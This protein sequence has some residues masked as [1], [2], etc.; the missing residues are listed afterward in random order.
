M[1]STVDKCSSDD[2]KQF[3]VFF[4][5]LPNNTP[6]HAFDDEFCRCWFLLTNEHIFPPEVPAGDLKQQIFEPEILVDGLVSIH[7]EGV[8][9]ENELAQTKKT[10]TLLGAFDVIDEA[11]VCPHYV[12]FTGRDSTLRGPVCETNPCM[13]RFLR[14][15]HHINI[16]GVLRLGV[17]KATLFAVALGFQH[18]KPGQAHTPHPHPHGN[19]KVIMQWKQNFALQFT[20]QKTNTPTPQ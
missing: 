5:D 7:K 19:K 16:E 18:N 2:T 9:G 15:E 13:R 8:D 10:K 20:K 14:Y 1:G 3:G 6:L 17:C 4:L 11:S 12:Q